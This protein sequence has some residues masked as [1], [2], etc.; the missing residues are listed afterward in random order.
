MSLTYLKMDMDTS[1]E[2]EIVSFRLSN[3]L[4][5]YLPKLGADRE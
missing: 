3:K 2:A 1:C 5:F 4:L